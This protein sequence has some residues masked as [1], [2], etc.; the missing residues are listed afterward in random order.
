MQISR[1]RVML[2][3]TGVVIA[4]VIFSLVGASPA[5][6]QASDGCPPDTTVQSLQICVEHAAGQGFIDN[7]GVTNSLLAKLGAAQNAIDH[8]QPTVAIN[9]LQA[10]MREVQAQAGKHIDQIRAE[11]IIAHAQ[12]V[13]QAV[14]LP[15]E[16]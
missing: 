7:Q 13:I 12:A 2:V 4:F 9:Q 11:H 15:S 3:G 1:L 10:L 5:K 16:P 8:N 14:R 6:A